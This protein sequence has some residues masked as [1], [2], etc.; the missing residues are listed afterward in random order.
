MSPRRTSESG[1]PPPSSE[2]LEGTVRAS[3]TAVRFQQA[4]EDEMATAT[5]TAKTAQEERSG[6]VPDRG[7]KEA[8]LSAPLRV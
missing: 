1:G 3:G 4:G 6:L 2:R 7:A 8:A 5:E